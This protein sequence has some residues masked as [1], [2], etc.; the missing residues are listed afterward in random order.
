MDGWNYPIKLEFSPQCLYTC[1]CKERKKLPI[2]TT[3][4]STGFNMGRAICIVE[5][6]HVDFCPPCGRQE[7]A[8]LSLPLGGQIGNI[9][10]SSCTGWGCWGEHLSA[11][12]FQNKAYCMFSEL[13]RTDHH[14]NHHPGRQ[15]KSR[16]KNHFYLP[17]NKGPGGGR[18]GPFH[19]SSH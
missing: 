9:L 10:T 14:N 15:Q 12:K 17:E 4:V 19:E 5:N 16:E 7:R 6:M 18:E 8:F 3:K 2:T 1:Y 13:C 11:D